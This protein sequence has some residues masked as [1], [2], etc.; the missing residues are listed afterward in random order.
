MILGAAGLS[1]LGAGGAARAQRPAPYLPPTERA[2][3]M[4]LLVGAEG[5]SGADLWVRGFAP[6]L[7]RH[8]KE[9][10]VRVVNRPGEGGLAALRE[11]AAAPVD[12][13]VLAYAPTPFLVARM[14][15]RRATGLLEGLRLL[16]AVTEEPVALVAAPGT[17]LATLRAQGSDRPLGL[18]PPV[19]AA[20]ILAVD[21]MPFL[22]MEQ[23]HFPSAS[24]ARQAA[25]SGNVAA[26]LVT[27]PE[28]LVAMREGRLAVL[29]LAAGARHPQLPDVPTLREEGIPLDGALRRG[30]AVPAG[31]APRP[32][33]HIAR[34]L[35]A[36]AAD[37]EFLA[38]AEW[39]AVLPRFR[40]EAEW[41][42]L[43]AQDLLEL[44]MR[45][46]TSPWQVVG[47]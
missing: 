33:A 11:L 15:E 28:A 17:D 7:E 10:Q 4:T 19:S 27:V 21:L 23:L 26:A 45:W 20:S 35:R 22:P 25:A 39:R 41:K 12:G 18:P 30:I 44:R 16:G 42:A 38:Q 32:A 1:A 36:A 8:I 6:F 46:E 5:G 3:D 40:D 24:A 29:G 2:R 43:V 34:A 13:S 37:P 14:V 31:I 47:G 9:V